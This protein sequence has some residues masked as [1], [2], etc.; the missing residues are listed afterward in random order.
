ERSVVRL[1][2]GQARNKQRHWQGVAVAACEQS[3][4]SRLAHIALPQMLPSFFATLGASAG[5]LRVL[6][7][8]QAHTGLA[9]LPPSAGDVLVLIGP[10][11]GLAAAESHAALE[12]GFLSVRLGPRVLRTETA[13][14]ALLALLQQRFG[15][16]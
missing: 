13:A 16:L 5:T 9:A 8:P 4:R 15:D 10:E 12:H 14:V 2:A 3:G 11:G 6:A 7:N 1:D